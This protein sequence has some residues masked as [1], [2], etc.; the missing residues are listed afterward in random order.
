MVISHYFVFYVAGCDEGTYGRN[1]AFNCSGHCVDNEYCDTETGHCINGC[2]SGYYMPYCNQCTFNKKHFDNHIFHFENKNPQSV[3]Y[4]FNLVIYFKY[5][6][7]N[8]K[9]YCGHNEI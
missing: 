2:K 9:H 5:R 4:A 1:C 6:V 7:V 3:I 8:L